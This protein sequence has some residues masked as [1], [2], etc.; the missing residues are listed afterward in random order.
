MENA[1][2]PFWSLSPEDKAKFAR[3][4]TKDRDGDS[5]FVGNGTELINECGSVEI[6][7]AYDVHMCGKPVSL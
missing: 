5:G 7:E 1:Y 4:D 2:K 3:P 6:R